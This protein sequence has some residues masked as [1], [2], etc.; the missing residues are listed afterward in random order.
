MMTRR[1]LIYPILIALAFALVFAWDLLTGLP[2]DLERALILSVAGCATVLIG[3]WRN[4]RRR[5]RSARTSRI[6]NLILLLF[7]AA[8]VAVSGYRFIDG[9]RSGD[10]LASLNP[11]WRVGWEDRPV[12]YLAMMALYLLLTAIFSAGFLAYAHELRRPSRNRLS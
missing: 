5:G 4:A 8:M 7:C 3:D 11:H 9:L 2:F 12:G 1:L 6:G 10:A